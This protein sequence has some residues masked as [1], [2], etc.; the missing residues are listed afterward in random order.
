LTDELRLKLYDAAKT[1]EDKEL[2]A[3]ILTSLTSHL[4]NDLQTDDIGT[5][6][7][8]A[9]QIED[10]LAR[11]NALAHLGRYLVG[12]D[13]DQVL[14]AVEAIKVKAHRPRVL[15]SLVPNATKAQ[16]ERIFEATMRLAEGWGDVLPSYPPVFES[17]MA[18]LH[19][20]ELEGQDWHQAFVLRALVS[21]SIGDIQE[22]AIEA[23]LALE[24]GEALAD[25]FADVSYF[26]EDEKLERALTKATAIHSNEYRAKAWASLARRFPDPRKSH[27]ISQARVAAAN[28][29]DPQDRAQSLITIGRACEGQERAVVF[30]EAL[31]A[32]VDIH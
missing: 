13:L 4:E 17:V 14:S 28:V 22:R 32:I 12:Q 10:E 2:Q 27:L 30:A 21:H 18:E 7:T 24:N 23:I 9:L 8:Q 6:L 20:A 5:A 11:A 15:A 31:G 19:R 29:E 3:W 25:S 1:F 16:Q 26:L